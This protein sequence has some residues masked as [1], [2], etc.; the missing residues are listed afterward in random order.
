MGSKVCNLPEAN[1]HLLRIFK[2]TDTEARLALG[3]YSENKVPI[4]TSIPCACS[5][6]INTLSSPKTH[7]LEL[8]EHIYDLMQLE[9]LVIF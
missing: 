5:F 9:I 1:F 3:L 8:N 2:E 4:C 7:I 6:N